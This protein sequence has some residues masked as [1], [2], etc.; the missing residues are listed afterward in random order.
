MDFGEKLF[1][2]RKEKGI[3]QEALA[4]QLNT[5]RQAI[6]KWENGQ[7]Y[8]ET[9]KLLMMGNIFEVSIDYLLKDTEQS[10]QSTDCGFYVSKEMAEGYFMNRHKFGKYIAAGL[11]VL[12]LAFIPYFF[13]DQDPAKYAILTLIM[14]VIGVGIITSAY[15]FEEDQYKI[16]SQEPLLFD[17]HYIKELKKKYERIKKKYTFLM[18]LGTIIFVI[19]FLPLIFEKKNLTS[20]FFV[21]YYSICIVFMAIGIY[22]LTRIGTILDAYKLLAKNE[23]HT[24]RISFKIKRKIRRKIDDF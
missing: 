16:L 10:N 7:G 15:S 6:S 17:E 9:E 13:F 19:G 23:E 22:I 18:F 14:A 2:L 3:S 11:F 20:G 5:T 8:P 1:K 12:A 4:E 24:G 21:S